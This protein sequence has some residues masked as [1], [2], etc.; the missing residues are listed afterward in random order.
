MKL[1]QERHLTQVWY[2]HQFFWVSNLLFAIVL[3]I[4]LFAIVAFKRTDY[5][6]YSFTLIEIILSLL[7]VGL[8]LKTKSVRLRK[9]EENLIPLSISNIKITPT[10]KRQGTIN[11][12]LEYRI[13]KK[14]EVVFR[15]NA[16]FISTKVKRN[17]KDFLQIE[18][19]LIKYLDSTMPELR[20]IL[21][22]IE[23]T[24]ISNYSSDHTSVYENRL[25]SI[26]KFLH[27]I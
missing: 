4:V 1:E 15:L 24:K 20:N 8:M 12:T 21:P 26:D 7:A 27:A 25:R 22:A 10:N 18:D 9:L 19:Y 14:N 6:A 23:K 16:G 3:Y 11:I 17:L 13:N 2:C 5:V